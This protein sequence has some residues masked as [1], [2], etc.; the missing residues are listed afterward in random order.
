[1]ELELSQTLTD[2][3]HLRGNYSFL[4]A[5]DEAGN[6]LPRRPD[7]MGS[8]DLSYTVSRKLSLGVGLRHVGEALDTAYTGMLKAYNLADLRIS[9]AL[10]D[11]ISLIG[12]IENLSDTRY[13]TA[14]GYGQ[15]GR[16]VWLGLHTRLF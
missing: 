2:T 5:R 8:L 4:H 12:R 15:T 16:R 1:M 7:Q 10:N 13:E 11:R 6:L 3:L 14:G 9:F